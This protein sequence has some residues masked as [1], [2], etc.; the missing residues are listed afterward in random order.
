MAVN[1][2]VLLEPTPVTTSAT[3]ASYTSNGLTTIIDKCVLTNVGATAKYATVYLVASGGSAGDTTNAFI[4]RK[5]LQPGES[6]T[7]PEIVGSALAAGDALQALAETAGYIIIRSSG[8]LI[9]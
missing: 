6:Y 8:R 7:C 1:V 2:A 3:G 4:Y 9:S 5:T